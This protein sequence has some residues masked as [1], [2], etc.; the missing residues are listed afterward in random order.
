[1]YMDINSYKA[2]QQWAKD[3]EGVFTIADLKVALNENAEATFYRKL[4]K[5]VNDGTLIKVKRG[6]Y[7]TRDATLTTISSRIDPTSYISTG[8][9]LAQKAIIGSI[10]ARKVQAVKMGRPR[11]YR[12][13]LGIIEHLSINPKYYFGFRPL[14]GILQA[15]PEKAYLDICYYCFKGKSFSFNP[16]SDINIQDLDFGIIAG[17]LDR[18]DKRFVTFFNSIWKDQ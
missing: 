15:T 9:V 3:L 12:C 7:T 17:Y 2:I 4:D 11:T 16:A 14:N 13:E 1:M 5:L 8:T 10:P 6:I 18:F